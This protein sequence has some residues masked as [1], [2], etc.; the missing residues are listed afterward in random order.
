LHAKPT[1]STGWAFLFFLPV[2][3]ELRRMNESGVLRD[4]PVHEICPSA[5]SGV[6]WNRWRAAA[7]GNEEAASERLHIPIGRSGFLTD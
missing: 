3:R 2:S 6:E 1:F 4:Y 7:R 5:I